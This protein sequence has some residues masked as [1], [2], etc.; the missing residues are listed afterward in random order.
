M[1][2]ELD[3]L[4]EVGLVDDATFARAV[5]EHQMRVRRAGRRAVVS[6]LAAKGVSR[7]TIEETLASLGGDEE[8][9][10]EALALERA[11]GLAG[12]RPEK[13]YARLVGL[14]QRRGYDGSIARAAAR[15]ALR[16]SEEA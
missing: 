13:A 11:R 14:L 12:V 2:R 4:E 3:R 10:A 15:W 9:R 16:S 8:E 7:G 6:A 1:E 5:A